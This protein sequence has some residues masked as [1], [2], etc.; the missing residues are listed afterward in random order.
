MGMQVLELVVAV[1]SEAQLE[2]AHLSLQVQLK[3][4]ETVVAYDFE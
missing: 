2:G 3:V 1:S 4:P